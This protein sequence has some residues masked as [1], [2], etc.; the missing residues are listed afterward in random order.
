MFLRSNSFYMPPT[1]SSFST[2]SFR[3]AYDVT[4]NMTRHNTTR[5]DTIRCFRFTMLQ[6]SCTH[7]GAPILLSKLL[8]IRFCR[9]CCARDFSGRPA[10][11]NT[12]FVNDLCTDRKNLETLRIGTLLPES[13][14]I[15]WAWCGCTWPYA[16]P[17][18]VINTHSIGSRK[19]SWDFACA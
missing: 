6:R 17:K 18:P 3:N 5:H 9:G 16:F 7:L 2:C 4:Y 15:R 14:D 13:L 19:T 10:R 11:E 12:V 8:C 1:P